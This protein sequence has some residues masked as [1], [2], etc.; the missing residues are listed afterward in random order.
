MG[1]VP[2]SPQAKGWLSLIV[3]LACLTLLAIL[4]R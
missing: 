3:F 1:G 4:T 2:V